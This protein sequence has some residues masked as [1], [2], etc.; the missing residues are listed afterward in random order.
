MEREAK[1]SVRYREVGSPNI[2]IPNV[3]YILKASLGEAPYPKEL[4]ISISAAANNNI[5]AIR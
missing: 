2:F 4:E 1:N 5:R 3:V